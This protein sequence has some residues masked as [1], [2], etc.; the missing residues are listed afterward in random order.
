MCAQGSG[1]KKE[2]GWGDDGQ[3]CFKGQAGRVEAGE[4]GQ[5][6]DDRKW[7]LWPLKSLVL[8]DRSVPGLA[9]Q[10]KERPGSIPEIR[11]P[12]FPKPNREGLTFRGLCKVLP[13]W[14]QIISSGLEQREGGHHLR[15]R[16]CR[17]YK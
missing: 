14:A 5:A 3:T 4:A 17:Q 9:A 12:P 10:A 6:E 7:A 16:T 15:T 8:G 2:V 11:E 13:S 1:G